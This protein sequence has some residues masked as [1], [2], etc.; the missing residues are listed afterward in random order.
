MDKLI[1][2]H[3]K[4][5]CLLPFKTS[6][7]PIRPLRLVKTLLVN[8]QKVVNC[9]RTIDKFNHSS[10]TAPN[11]CGERHL[12]LLMIQFQL[13][14]LP[15]PIGM[16]MSSMNTTETYTRHFPCCHIQRTIY[17]SVFQHVLKVYEKLLSLY[18]DA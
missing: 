17:A 10:S 15:F 3:E 12:I 16:K 13:M 7:H 1:Y 18:W 14:H 8:S 2:K 6:H 11:L 5:A 9:H 4:G